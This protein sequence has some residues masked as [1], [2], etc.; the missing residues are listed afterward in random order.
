MSA[1]L[2]LSTLSSFLPQGPAFEPPVRLA[3]AGEPI[4]VESPGYAA[5][6]WHDVDGDGKKDLV[7]GQFREG[8]IAWYRN[9][10]KGSFAARAWLQA[11]G[12]DA[13]VP[14]VW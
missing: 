14:G 10:G 5:P 3:A 9:L 6:S 11:G 2:L 1:I 13:V 8:K 12:K 7:V 4:R